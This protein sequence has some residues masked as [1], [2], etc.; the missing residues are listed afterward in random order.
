MNEKLFQWSS[1]MAMILQVAL[2]LLQGDLMA[3]RAHL[4]TWNS[5]VQLTR[6]TIMQ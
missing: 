6:K 5:I 4:S 3:D 1:N 2:G